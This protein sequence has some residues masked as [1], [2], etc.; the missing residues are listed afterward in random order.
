[1]S[2]TAPVAEQVDEDVQHA[3]AQ[4]AGY[5]TLREITLRNTQ[6]DSHL[7]L[8]SVVL[9]PWEV[10]DIVKQRVA[11]GAHTY[12][13]KLEPLTK[14][15]VAERRETATTLEGARLVDGQHIAPPWPDYVGLHPEEIIQRMR[16]SADRG[17][18][19]RARLYERGG[20]AREPILEYTPPAE[21]APW[22][23]YDNW[24]VREILEKLPLLGREAINGVMAYEAAHR[25]RPAVISW[26]PET[27]TTEEA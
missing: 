3:I 21:R 9:S 14:R 13:A 4:T 2:L 16:D 25:M 17:L 8:K 1:M 5:L 26:E 22:S 24:N 18:I 20:L 15:E 6:G 7:H 27:D 11:E 19:E 12:L 23:D 10:S